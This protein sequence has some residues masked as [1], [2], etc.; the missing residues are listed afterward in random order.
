MSCLTKPQYAKCTQAKERKINGRVVFCAHVQRINSTKT[1]ITIREI[2]QRL[3]EIC[4]TF[5]LLYAK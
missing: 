4:V 3:H 5:S 1:R 2:N